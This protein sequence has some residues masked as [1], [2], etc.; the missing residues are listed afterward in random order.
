M[1]LVAG[2]ALAGCGGSPLSVWKVSWLAGEVPAS[3]YK[4][5][6]ITETT[7]EK[8]TIETYAGN[9][10]LYKAAKGTYQLR[11]G[12]ETVLDGTESGGT[13]EFA[14]TETTTQVDRPENPTMTVILAIDQKITLTM[15]GDTFTG[16]W[17]HTKT[18]RCEGTCQPTFQADNPDCTVTDQIKGTKVPVEIIHPE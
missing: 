13:F 6:K 5:G 17:E 7:T 14:G 18:M 3:C 16:T 1:A 2:L 15:D 8:T 11:I 10:E 12:E 9:W 4:D